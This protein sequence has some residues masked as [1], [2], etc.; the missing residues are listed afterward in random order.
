MELLK[1]YPIVRNNKKRTYLNIECAF[2]IETTSYLQGDEKIALMYLWGFGIGEDNEI[3][4][5]RTWAEFITLCET[6]QERYN[7]HN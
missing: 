1:D 2:D 3:V 7:L 4:T 5:G 6:L